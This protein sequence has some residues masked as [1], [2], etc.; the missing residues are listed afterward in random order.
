MAGY[1]PCDL[2]V[3][4]KDPNDSHTEDYITINGRGMNAA[5]ALFSDLPIVEYQHGGRVYKE[6]DIVFIDWIPVGTDD[7]VVATSIMSVPVTFKNTRTGKIEVA[8]IELSGKYAWTTT[9][10]GTAAVR[11]KVCRYTIPVGMRMVLGHKRAFTSRLLLNPV[12][13]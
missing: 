6:N 9:L 13:A 4:W 7:W 1:E 11:A 12:D 5:K 3:G 10:V 2:I 8:Y